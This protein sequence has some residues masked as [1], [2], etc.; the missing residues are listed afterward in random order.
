[1]D[2]GASPITVTPPATIDVDFDLDPLGAISGTVR[3]AAT[4]L[5]IP[6]IP[7]YVET[8]AG[9]LASSPVNPPTTDANGAYT[10]TGLKSGGHIVYTQAI[11]DGWVN[12]LYNDIPCAGVNCYNAAPL[13]A[14]VTVTA[15][16]TTPGI[17]FA[18]G[19]TGVING[20]VRNGATGQPIPLATVAAFPLAGG[21]TGQAQA[22][23]Q[24]VY[25]LSGMSDGTYYLMASESGYFSEVWPDIHCL[26]GC[27]PYLAGGTVLTLTTGATLTRD[28]NLDA[29]GHITGTVTDSITGAPVSGIRVSAVDEDGEV[30][31]SAVTPSNGAFTLPLPPGAYYLYTSD[32]NTPQTVIYLHEY[33]NNVPCD[34]PCRSEDAPLYGTPVTVAAGS[35]TAARD[36]ALLRRAVITGRVTSA[37]TGA[38]LV[39]KTV[40]AFDPRTYT[41]IAA[42]QTDA[43]G[44]YILAIAQTG[45]LFVYTDTSD[46]LNEFHDNVGC[47]RFCDFEE[48]GEATPI[49]VPA[50]GTVVTGKDFALD[51]G[52][53]ISGRVT[54]VITGTGI[55]FTLVAAIRVGT[56]T[57]VWDYT[58]GGGIYVL[59][60]LP[61]GQY[62]L[63]T[64][65]ADFQDG[66]RN[67]IYDDVPCETE[68]LDADVLRLGTRLTLSEGQSLID[69]DF[70]LSPGGRLTGKVVDADTGDPVFGITVVLVRGDGATP[71][72][73]AS[74]F[75]RNDGSFTVKGLA[76]GTYYLH[77]RNSVGYIDQVY[78]DLSCGG[79]CSR[80]FAVLG[81]PVIIREGA[82]NSGLVIKVK[83]GGRIHGRITDAVSGNPRSTGVSIYNRERRRVSTGSSGANGN[84]VTG[85]GLPDGTYYALAS[86]AGFN[87]AA[88]FGN[89]P[90]TGDC[91]TLLTTG[92]PIVIAAGEST[93]DK[94]FA[95]ERGGRIAGS[96]TRQDNGLPTFGGSLDVY[97]AAGQWVTDGSLD[98]TGDWDVLTALP[99]GTYYVATTF[100]SGLVDERYDNLPCAAD[101]CSAPEIM[102]GAPITVTT[103]Q[104]TG[105]IDFALTAESGVPGPPRSP[106]AVT[107]ASGVV[108]NWFS[109]V[110]G[111]APLSYIVEAGLTPGAADFSLPSAGTTLTIPSVPPGRYYLRVRGVNAAGIGIASREFELI[112]GVGN[113]VVPI[114]PTGLTAAVVGRRVLIGWTAPAGGGPAVD[115]VMEVGSATGLSDIAGQTVAIPAFTFEPVPD[116][117]YFIRVRARNAAGA[118]EPSAE[119]MLAVGGVPAPPSRPFIDTAVVSGSTVTI[120]WLPPLHGPVSRYEID[121]GTLLGRSDIGTIAVGNVTSH[122]I[123][124]VPPGTYYARVRAI[125]ARGSSVA[126]AE[127][128][129]RVP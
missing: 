44:V 100:T 10:V 77:T 41:D 38:A 61:P 19:Q 45:P 21:A 2:H 31:T 105:G 86:S 121:A 24:G 7:I 27:N 89:I 36:F 30:A 8:S 32:F 16:A 73:A 37:Q 59:N 111:G 117:V 71:E 87:L 122:T 126:S 13:A 114:A 63:Y 6:G 76:S 42:A 18:L 108:I 129:V 113:L 80:A 9:V 64:S 35:T 67:E 57:T 47:L 66:L 125:N 54:S 65:D 14:L 110:T 12:E 119:T 99:A 115:Y 104:T 62:V 43:D 1:M 53:L 20:T 102:L 78:P 112:V 15:P 109:P 128:I 56:N 74:D 93:T 22:N 75:S 107:G 3:S 95:L 28:F 29:G 50:Q 5:P 88:V 123:A 79:E 26:P 72:T 25:S 84:Y 46:Y 82:L 23:A 49:Q 94:N 101:F 60:H 116:G 48:F 85:P 68:C 17:D 83:R 40:I 33:W 70:D 127:L 106:D 98:I 39:G 96:I 92:T 124:G 58:D 103:G 4:N 51:R 34:G 52:A 91:E 118:G 81:G 55:D 69:I 11:L 90:C 120:L 97:N